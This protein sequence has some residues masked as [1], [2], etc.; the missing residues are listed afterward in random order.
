[1]KGGLQG[2]GFGQFVVEVGEGD[3]RG[4]V[5]GSDVVQHFGVD[6][7]GGGRGGGEVELMFGSGKSEMGGFLTERGVFG[8][9]GDEARLVVFVD[10]WFITCERRGRFEVGVCCK[11]HLHAPVLEEVIG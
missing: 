2:G 4:F 10:Y 9:V 8:A 1:M 6:F 7:C 3:G 5:S 11:A